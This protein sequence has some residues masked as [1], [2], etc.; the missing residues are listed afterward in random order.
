MDLLLGSLSHERLIMWPFMFATFYHLDFVLFHLFK[1]VEILAQT[2]FG[3][4]SFQQV[5]LIEK[6]LMNVL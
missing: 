3:E 2:A 5:E 1:I 6:V 4:V